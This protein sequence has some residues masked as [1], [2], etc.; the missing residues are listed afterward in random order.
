MTFISSTEVKSVYHG[1]YEYYI[2]FIASR[3]EINII[4]IFLFHYTCIS[5]Q[6]WSIAD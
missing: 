6:F 5:V 3:D 1:S 4:F 2:H